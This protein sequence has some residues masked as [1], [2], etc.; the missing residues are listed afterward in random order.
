M[1]LVLRSSVT[2]KIFNELTI[3]WNKLKSEIEFLPEKTNYDKIYSLIERALNVDWSQ[4]QHENDNNWKHKKVES[5]DIFF[6]IE[7]KKL[8]KPK[9]ENINDNKREKHN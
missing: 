5:Y 2:N 6:D 1:E 8:K 3:F 4:E 7:S 9:N